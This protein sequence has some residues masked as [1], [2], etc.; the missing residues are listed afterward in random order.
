[1]NDSCLLD[2]KQQRHHGNI[3]NNSQT[4]ELL[5]MLVTRQYT[6]HLNMDNQILETAFE[7]GKVFYFITK[8]QEEERMDK[9]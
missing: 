2:K 8:Y 9:G 6:Q 5:I 7:K 1:M 4:T 3:N